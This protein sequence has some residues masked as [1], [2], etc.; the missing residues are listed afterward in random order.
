M[1][2]SLVLALVAPLALAQSLCGQYDYYSGNGW[3]IN[4][5]E[6][7]AASGTGTQCTYVDSDNTGGISWHTDW[8]W[9]GGDNSVKSYPYS[10]RDL[11]T[12]KLVSNIGSITNSAEWEYEGANLRCDVAYD[13]FTSADPNHATSSGDYE[14]MIW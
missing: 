2:Q 1:K 6:W 14:L 3:Y 4:N 11:P 10:G 12:K 5:N 9:S 7:G 8:D 13:L